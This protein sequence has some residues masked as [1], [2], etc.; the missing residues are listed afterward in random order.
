MP[1]TKG[2]RTATIVKDLESGLGV[3]AIAKKRHISPSTVQY[4]LSMGKEAIKNKGKQPMRARHSQAISH[5]LVKAVDRW[6]QRRT[7]AEKITILLQNLDTH[8]EK[9]P[10]VCSYTE[11]IHHAYN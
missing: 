7:A 6:W 2:I 8:Y 10:P 4:H 3:T 11:R 1:L 9:S 5:E